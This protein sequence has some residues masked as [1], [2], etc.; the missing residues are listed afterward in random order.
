M[1]IFVQDQ[2]YAP[3]GRAKKIA[4][5]VRSAGP[6]GQAQRLGKKT[7]SGLTLTKAWIDS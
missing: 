5:P 2:A 3:E 7:I 1:R 6:T 4:T